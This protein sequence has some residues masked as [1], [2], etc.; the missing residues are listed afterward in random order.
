MVTTLSMP[1]H[2]ND[3]QCS[4]AHL[5]A[6]QHI[7][8]IMVTFVAMVSAI[9]TLLNVLKD[10]EP[11]YTS[12]LARQGWINELLEGHPAYIHCELGVSWEVF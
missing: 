8:Q 10:P 4:A 1:L 7:Q 5:W 11:Y 12:I 3:E 6:L 9:L 2:K